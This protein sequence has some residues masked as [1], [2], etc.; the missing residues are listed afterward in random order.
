[1]SHIEFH[2]MSQANRPIMT[3]DSESR[4]REYLAR[5]RKNA[6]SAKLMRVTRVL[7]ELK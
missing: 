1:M 7:E 5:V 4:A 3:F 2:I 6:P